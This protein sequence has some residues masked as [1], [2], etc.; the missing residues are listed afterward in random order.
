MN[1]TNLIVDI[2]AKGMYTEQEL[3][4]LSEQICNFLS[5][6]HGNGI[7]VGTRYDKSDKTFEVSDVNIKHPSSLVWTASWFSGD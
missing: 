3:R 1:K 2:E 7:T 4:Y 5:G 6:P